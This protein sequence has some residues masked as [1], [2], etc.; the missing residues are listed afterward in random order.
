VILAALLLGERVMRVQV[1]GIVAALAAIVL[2]A[3]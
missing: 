3:S 1:V 2:I